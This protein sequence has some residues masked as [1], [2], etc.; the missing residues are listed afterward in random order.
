MQPS[1]SMFI[2]EIKDIA[3]KAIQDRD[4]DGFRVIILIFQ[5]HWAHTMSRKKIKE[6][7]KISNCALDI[8]DIAKASDELPIEM[9][10]LVAQLEGGWMLSRHYLCHS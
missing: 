3:I 2:D 10:I 5:K 1:L 6:V 9:K 4:G 7:R 8:I